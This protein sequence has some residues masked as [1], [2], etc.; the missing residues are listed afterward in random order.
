MR[1]YPIGNG[2]LSPVVPRY[3]AALMDALQLRGSTADSLARLKRE[4]WEELLAFADRA[5]LTLA[6]AQLNFS[7][8]PAWVAHRLGKNLADNAL[9]SKRVLA[10]YVEAADALRR[11]DVPHLVLKGF[12]QAPQYVKHP[13]LRMQ[14]DLDF[15]CPT[16]DIPRAQ[17]ALEAIGYKPVEEHDFRRADHIPAL[18]RTGNWKWMGNMYDPE[19]PVSIE[20]H[21]CLWNEQ[22]SLIEAAEVEG[23]WSRRETRALD[24]VTF[25]ALQPVDQ[26]GYL[27]LHVVRE[28]IW[29]ESIVH[30]VHEL[31][32]FLDAHADDHQFWTEWER[33][34]SPRVRS[35]EAIAFWLAQVWFSCE[36]SDAVRG[37]IESLPPEQK[38]W[39]NQFG[40]SPLEGMFRRNKDGR[41]LQLMLTESWTSRRTVFHSAIGMPSISK[42]LRRYVS[43]RRQR[44]SEGVDADGP[45]AYSLYVAGRLVSDL[46][47]T[48]TFMMHGVLLWFSGR[49]IRAQFLLFMSASFFLTWACLH[50]S[51]SSTYS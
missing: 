20:L 26:L 28:I 8:I 37:Q 41:L 6:L 17:T 42:I 45:A 15:L 24:H 49:Q 25:P 33:M 10:T 3:F 48:M 19:M 34:H 36:V 2:T 35:F 1:P 30:H 29:G 39:L 47:A 40:G 50:T 27:A 46:R 5:H 7:N 4:D 9:R 11:A 43:F 38:T 22:A 51:F 12:T 13:R 16:N 21:F 23:F 18:T 14:S 32:V 44:N 31:A